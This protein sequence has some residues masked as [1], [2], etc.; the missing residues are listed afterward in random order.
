MN[1]RNYGVIE[2]RLTRD[3]S[4]ITN[5]D[6]SRKVFISIAARD[7]FKNADGKRGTQFVSL[8]AFIS[9]KQA[10]NGVYGYM[11][12]GDMV[13]LHYTVK[14]FRYTPKDS[15]EEVFG[16]TLFI[17]EVDL[18]DNNK[19]TDG[20]AEADAPEAASEAPAAPEAPAPAPAPKA[21]TAKGKKSNNAVDEP[22]G[23]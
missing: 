7:N 12:K 19:R 10:S 22:F 16:Q 1:I 20:D 23:A 5:K 11:H 8:E 18:K 17:Q 14:C 13:A 15:T 9:N 21:K 4:I 6:G 2:G 3:P